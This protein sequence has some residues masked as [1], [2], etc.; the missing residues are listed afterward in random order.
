MFHGFEGYFENLE[1]P[2]SSG[3]ERSKGKTTKK[4]YRYSKLCTP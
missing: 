4:N 3:K 2:Y 1:I